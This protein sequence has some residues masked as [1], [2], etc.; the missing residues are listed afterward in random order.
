MFGGGGG[1]LDVGGYGVFGV[2][3]SGWGVDDVLVSL[4]GRGGGGVGVWVFGECGV[5]VRLVG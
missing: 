4:G 5:G 3:G 2:W 1:L